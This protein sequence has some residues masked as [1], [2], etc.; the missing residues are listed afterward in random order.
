MT[1]ENEEPV[2]LSPE[3]RTEGREPDIAND[4][5]SSPAA[6]TLFS[7]EMTLHE[8]FLRIIKYESLPLTDSVP[9]GPLD[10]IKKL[11]T[12]FGIEEWPDLA[13]FT[14]SDVNDHFKSFPSTEITL[15]DI[16]A[17]GYLFKFAK[18]QTTVPPLNFTMKEVILRVDMAESLS[19]TAVNSSS[20]SS[21]QDRLRKTVPELETFKGT[22]EDSFGWME[23]TLTKLGT[24]GLARYLTEPTLVASNPEVAES[25][26]YALRR[27][28]MSGL[29]KHVS[30]DLMGKKNYS[31]IDLWKNIEQYYDVN[32]EQG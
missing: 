22:D 30:E 9:N 26:F 24:A 10:T 6:T 1:D 23:D 25:V 7:T 18:V 17:M 19:S 3:G 2:L 8:R 4:S 31:P 14:P 5:A 28:T 15:R 27:A 32:F 16:K 12:S 20:A 21:N 29:A 11:F 13:F